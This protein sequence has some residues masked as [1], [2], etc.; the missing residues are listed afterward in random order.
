MQIHIMEALPA[1]IQGLLANF[2]ELDRRNEQLEEARR[3]H[4]NEHV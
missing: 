4:A 2:A 3:K 1:E